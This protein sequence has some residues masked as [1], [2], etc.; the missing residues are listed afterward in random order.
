MQQDVNSWM[1]QF[2]KAMDSLEEDEIGTTTMHPVTVD[3]F[4][5]YLLNYVGFNHKLALLLD[6][7]GTLAPI[8]PHPDLAT[9]PPETKN[10]LQRLSN[11]SDVYV[12]VIS[13][14]NVDNVKAMVGIEGITYA[15]NHGLEIQ[16]PDGSKFIHP[17]PMEYEGKMTKLLKALQ[18]EVCHHGAWVENKGALLTFHYRETPNELR[19]E[20]VSKARQLITDNGFSVTEAHCAVEAKPPVQWNK[21]RAS[22]YILR[23]AFGVDWSERIKIIYAGDDVTDEDAMMALKGMA[24][25]FRVTNAQ[26]VKT[27]AERRLP[28]TDSVLTML[29]WVERHFMRRKPRSNSLTYKNR[30]KDCVKMQLAFELVPSPNHSAANSSDERD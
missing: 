29:K 20:L 28:S 9:L 7:D 12:A 6:Y 17:M 15:G 21:G 14:R 13:G 1:R 22:I 16:H 25:T 11:H 4:D 24:A 18:E 19:A 5:D 10:V 23:T 27:S 26:I 3:D 2:L 30:K 8:A